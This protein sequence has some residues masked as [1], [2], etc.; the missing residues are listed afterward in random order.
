MEAIEDASHIPFLPLDLILFGQ[1]IPANT[2]RRF[3]S[4]PDITDI[5]DSLP[6]IG[7]S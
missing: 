5:I 6:A 3:N 7:D 2:D 1:P 4:W